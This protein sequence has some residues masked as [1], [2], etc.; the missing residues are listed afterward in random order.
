MGEHVGCVSALQWTQEETC[1]SGSW[2]HS[3]RCWD[4][5]TGICTQ[6]MYGGTPIYDIDCS[7]DSSAPLI[8]TGHADRTIRLWD[9]RSKAKLVVGQYKSHKAWIPSVQWHPTNSNIFTSA[10]H[11]GTVKIWDKRSDLPLHT[12]Q[13]HDEKALC[14]I[15]HG[16][17][18]LLSG[19]A[20]TK[21][22]VHQYSL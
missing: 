17:D 11:D 9:P 18:I 7:K 3:V 1:W 13:S 2:D 14:V 12:I 6:K 8:L 20:D 19:G 4:L 15:W 21:L 22:K 16:E 10:S 5:P